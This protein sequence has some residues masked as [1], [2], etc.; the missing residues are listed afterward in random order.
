LIV[1]TITNTHVS[2]DPFLMDWDGVT[3]F[4]FSIINI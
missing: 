1:D 2:N 3:N 4:S